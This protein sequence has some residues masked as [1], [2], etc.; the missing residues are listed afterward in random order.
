MILK[1][2]AFIYRKTGIYLAQKEENQYANSSEYM[3][4]M[5]SMV[6]HEENDLSIESI[7]SILIGSWQAKYGFYRVFNME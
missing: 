4:A 7:H 3:E 6:S 1:L 2:K 5:I